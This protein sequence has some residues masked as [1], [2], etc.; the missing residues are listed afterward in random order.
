MKTLNEIK[1]W[2]I[3]LEDTLYTGDKLF[4]GAKEFIEMLRAER[5]SFRFIS[6]TTV[7]SRKLIVEKL[8]SLGIVA[9][10]KEIFTASSAAAHILKSFDGIKCYFAVA[11]NLMED[12]KEIEISEKNPDYVVMG[13]VG[14][15]MNYE[16]MNKI[17][18]FV[19]A[20]AGCD[21]VAEE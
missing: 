12:F 19:M 17:F 21:S 8:Q 16:L 1:G 5:R 20:G 3:D 4:H 9:Q 10:G 13:D 2:L 6:N 7:L 18:K 14:T 11:D 15:A